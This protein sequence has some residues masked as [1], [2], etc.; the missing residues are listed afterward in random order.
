MIFHIQYNF[1]LKKNF[2]R[3]N[4]ISLPDVDSLFN[5]KQWSDVNPEHPVAVLE[6][7]T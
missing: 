1:R 4:L 7:L 6:D 3:S 5:E 2:F